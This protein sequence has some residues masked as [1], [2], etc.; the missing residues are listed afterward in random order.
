MSNALAIAAVTATLRNVISNDPSLPPG[1][2]VTAQS[3]E[4]AH[5]STL[6]NQINLF[7]YQI[8]PNA[9]W[10]N[11]DI[12]S[13]VKS[14]ETGVPPL[15]LNLYYIVT[16]Y[17]RE[18]ADLVEVTTHNLLGRA[19]SILHDHP[20]LGPDEI[21]QA[22]PNNDLHTQIERVRITLQP[23]SLEEMSKLWMM[24]QTR[25]R[26][27]AAYE[28]AVVLIDSTLPARTPLPILTRGKDDGGISS[29]PNLVP[30]IPTLLDLKP[31]QQ[32]S[33]L[34][35]DDLTLI[36]HDLHPE[37]KAATGDTKIDNTK[38]K[39][40]FSNPNWKQPIELPPKS[41][42]TPTQVSV[43]LPTP[44]ANAQVQWP[45]GFYTVS[46]AFKDT[47][48]RLVTTTNELSFSLA[49]RI[50]ANPPISAVRNPVSKAVT[51]TLN[52][53]P[54]VGAT[55]R[56]TLL[57]ADSQVLADP[58]PPHPP[59]APV[60]PRDHLSF[61]VGNIAAGD[62]FVRLRVDGVDSLLVIR[63]DEQNLPPIFDETQKVTVPA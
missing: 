63:R 55:Q 26:T 1:T 27:S 50:L 14:G 49:P 54:A 48:D 3:P 62:Y 4:E 35:G 53:S 39:I 7:L 47:K 28:V 19:M 59:N 37:D 11:R 32:P 24:F 2:H 61:H 6:N 9:A 41:E 57:L 40:R 58:P 44:P 18:N 38:T 17:H 36:G 13:R 22:L 45:A 30:P 10:R 20:L 29:Q 51:I 5:D 46:V 34:P 15:A 16:A 60:P 43:T 21:R 8:L 31:P 42:A 56:A 12:P 33:A 52:C 23:L 25:Y